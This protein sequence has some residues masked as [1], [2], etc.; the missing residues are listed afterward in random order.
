MK[1]KIYEIIRNYVARKA[2]GNLGKVVINDDKIV[3]YVDGRKLKKKEKYIHRYNLIFKCIPSKEEIFKTY[4]LEKPV[5]Y[6]IK[7]TDFDMEIRIMSSTKNCHVTFENC[8]FTG[9]IEIDFADHITFINN[10][11]E[12]QNYKNFWSIY[13]EGEFCISTR[14]KK[15]EINKLEFIND[16]IDVD[17]PETIP[18]YRAT[19]KSPKKK[20]IK[21]PIVEIWLYAKEIIMTNTD[22]VNAKSIVIGT[23]R[24]LL[25]ATNIR[26]Q[27]LEIDTKNFEYNYTAI[28]SDII[29]VKANKIL[30]D[31]GNLKGNSIFVNDVE[32]DKNNIRMDAET[33]KLQKERLE[34]LSTLKKIETH[35]EEQISQELKKE[36]LTK[37]LKR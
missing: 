31:Y 30:C 5:H 21:N 11:Y 34:L 37:V 35:A 7:D 32:M 19:D 9:A 27:E 10:I 2:T 4:N 29:S 14:A 33:V 6:I 12:A 26:T 17:Y 28:E 22:I 23:D 25:N 18:V 36:L 8:T 3:C 24:L 13:K 16:N 20:E 15:G 1:K